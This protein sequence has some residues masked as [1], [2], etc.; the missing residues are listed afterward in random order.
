MLT[1]TPRITSTLLRTVDAVRALLGS[2]EATGAEDDRDYSALITDLKALT[3][4]INPKDTEAVDIDSL[5][6]DLLLTADVLTASP[7]WQ[8]GD[9]DRRTSDRRQGLSESSLRVDVGL[10]DKLMNLVGAIGGAVRDEAGLAQPA[11][12]QPREPDVV[13]DDEDA[14]RHGSCRVYRQPSRTL[15]S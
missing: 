8:P 2:I 14:V 3:G 12:Q 13:F 1:L 4:G 6:S 9:E 15:Q 7:A 5:A 10:L 11:H